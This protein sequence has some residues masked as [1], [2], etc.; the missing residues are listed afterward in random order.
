MAICTRHSFLHIYKPLLLFALEDYFKDPSIDVLAK[1]FTSVNSMDLSAMPRLSILERQILAASDNKDMF[2][3]KFE[4]AANSHAAHH[5][6]SQSS[7]TVPTVADAEK[8]ATTYIDLAPGR[9]KVMN[10]KITISRDSHEFE[11]KVVYNGIQVPIRVPVANLPETVGDVR[12]TLPGIWTFGRPVQLTPV[13]LPYPAHNDVLGAACAEPPTPYAAPP[14]YNQ[15]AIYTPRHSFGQCPP[16][17]EED[18]FSQSRPSVRRSREP[19][20]GSLCF[21]QW[22]HA[23]RFHQTC[24]PVHRSLKG[25]RTLDGSRLY[26]RRQESGLRPSP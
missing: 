9:N 3:E 18:S 17:R 23:P 26:R 19:C 4:E 16:H 8:R 13:V 25:R 7:L 1:L 20:A 22:R 24:I 6:R 10:G 11:T 2:S 21:S 15:R 5:V 14:P 12:Y